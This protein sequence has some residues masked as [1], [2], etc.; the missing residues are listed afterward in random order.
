MSATG[1][2][3]KHRYRCPAGHT[4][5]E[6]INSHA[7][8]H[9]CAKA[10]RNGADADPEWHELLDTKTGEVVAFDD[11]REHWPDLSEVPAY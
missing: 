10:L 4:S 2:E 9:A 3:S 8:C 1:D 6:R 7:W 5:W 11:L